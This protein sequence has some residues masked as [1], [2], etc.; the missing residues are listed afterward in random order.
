MRNIHGLSKKC[1]ILSEHHLIWE[2]HQNLLAKRIW[3]PRDYSHPRLLNMKNASVY[4]APGE[5]SLSSGVPDCYCHISISWNLESTC[6]TFTY[7]CHPFVF[8][9]GV[10]AL[11]L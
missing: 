2:R 3:C 5:A 10:A 9:C 8:F 1:S 4:A 7:S 11:F 6:K